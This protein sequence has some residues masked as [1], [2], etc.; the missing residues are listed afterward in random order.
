M[1]IN[2]DVYMCH[3]QSAPSLLSFVILQAAFKMLVLTRTFD[4]QT[5]KPLKTYEERN[6]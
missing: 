4:F 6:E 2:P 3:F 5:F 1:Q